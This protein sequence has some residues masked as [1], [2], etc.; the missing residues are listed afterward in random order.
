MTQQFFNLNESTAY[1]IN[2]TSQDFLAGNTIQLPAIVA[3]SPSGDCECALCGQDGQL[4]EN[5]YCPDCQKEIAQANAEYQEKP[6][7]LDWRAILGD[8]STW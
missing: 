3:T 5:F 6:R 1:A 4:D 2:D 7:S 8:P